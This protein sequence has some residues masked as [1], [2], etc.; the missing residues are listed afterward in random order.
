MVLSTVRSFGS[1]GITMPSCNGRPACGVHANVNN[2]GLL[3]R[4][5]G[6]CMVGGMANVIS[7]FRTN[8]LS[9]GGGSKVRTAKT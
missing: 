1:N 5:F 3:G 7:T 6:R 8:R 2:H 9:N 4:V